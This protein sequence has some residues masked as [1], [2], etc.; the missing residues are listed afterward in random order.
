MPEIMQFV[1]ILIVGFAGSLALTPLSRQ[2]AMRLGVV[3][4][5]NQRKIHLDHKPMMGGLAIYVA[6]AAA[7]L[8]FSPPRH[9]REFGAVLAGAAVLALLGLIDD[10]YDLS[11]R[12][13]MPI[14]LLA[15]AALVATGVRMNFFGLPLLDGAMTVIWIFVITNATNY[16]DNMDGQSAGVTAIAAFFFMLIALTQNLSLV[17]LLA[18]AVLGSAFG[19]LVYN[20]NPSS[21][22]M[23]D[24]GALPLG[25]I[26][27]VLAVKLEF[28]QP[29]SLRWL[30][31]VFV[32]ALPVFDVNLVTWTRLFEHR[33]P[34][35]AGKDHTAHRLLSMGFGQRGTLL[36]VYGICVVFGGLA[37]LISAAPSDI[38]L[39]LAG[40]GVLLLGVLAGLMIWLRQ[41]Y[42]KPPHA[43]LPLHPADLEQ[44]PRS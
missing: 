20:F 7:L 34:A 27:A 15:A 21:T 38:A 8:L 12:T 10:R 35:Q 42:Q 41:R 39:R 23:G 30:I 14:M 43:H 40:F 17:S 13:K 37:L 33:S 3:D 25:F 29:F 44:A 1:P 24:M 16:L 22:F 36:I 2:L 5:P 31:P 9:V 6:L 11:W 26:L 4:K 32:L 18:A 28:D 19:F